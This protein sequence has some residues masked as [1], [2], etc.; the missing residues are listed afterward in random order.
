MFITKVDDVLAEEINQIYD[1]TLKRILTLSKTSVVNLI[2]ALFEK[3]FPIDSDITYNWTESVSD[4]L[5]KII[6]DAILTVNN[7]EKFHIECQINND[8]TIVIRVFEYGFQEALKYKNV[9]DDKII[10]KL[11]HAKII[12]LEPN[13]NTPSEVS[14]ILQT[15]DSRE[16]EYKVPTIKFLSYSIEELNKQ[17]MVILMPLYLLKLRKI[18]VY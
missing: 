15:P 13:S 6:A 12:Y 18:D 11:P 14:L 9:V 3:A 10:L 16:F 5:D 1:K 17:R 8:S 4:N 2:N 7:V